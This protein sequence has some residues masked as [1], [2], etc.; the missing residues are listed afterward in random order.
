MQTM[1]L[2]ALIHKAGQRSGQPLIMQRLLEL[3]KHYPEWDVWKTHP[4]CFLPPDEV[5]LIEVFLST[6]SAKGVSEAVGFTVKRV[7]ETIPLLEQ[8][9]RL[10]ME[11]YARS[12]AAMMEPGGGTLAQMQRILLQRPLPLLGN[13]LLPGYDAALWQSEASE[14]SWVSLQA[15][16]GGRGLPGYLEE[17]GFKTVP[18]DL[19]KTLERFELHAL[20]HSTP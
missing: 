14:A 15:L 19:Q 20:V 16:A 11:D 17:Q 6:G 8:K 3:L 18:P 12:M 1:M 5:T 10:G 2:N 4:L 13:S 9:L 7:H